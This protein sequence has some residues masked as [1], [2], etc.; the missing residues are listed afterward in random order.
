MKKQVIKLFRRMSRLI[1]ASM[2]FSAFRSPEGGNILVYIVMVMVIFAALGVTM[3]SLFSTS[4]GGSA[5]ADSERRAFNLY[6]SGY[7]Y[8]LSELTNTS[9]SSASINT[10]NTTTY[11]L[12][13]EGQF[14]LN[15]FGPWFDSVGSQVLSSGQLNLSLPRGKLPVD[16]TIPTG[17]PYVSVVNYDYPSASIP[18]SASAEIN[19][20]SLTD[21]THFTLNVRNDFVANAK[22]RICLAVH[23]QQDQAIAS[24]VPD[25]KVELQAQNIFPKYNGAI[26]VKRKLYFYRE[27]KDDSTNLVVTLTG[28]KDTSGSPPSFSVTTADY[29]ILS[30]ANYY[31]VPEGR[32]EAV[33]YG[34]KM[35]YAVNAYDVTPFGP[36]DPKPDIQFDQESDLS[37]KLT[38]NTTSGFAAVDNFNKKITFT[39][40]SGTPFASV[41]FN[42]TRAIGGQN[43]YCQSGACQF[44]AGIRAFFVM[45]FTGGGDGFTFSLLNASNNNTTSVGGD[46]Q[47][48]E[49]LGYAGDGRTGTNPATYIPLTLHGLQAPKMA[50]EFD[51]YYNNTSLVYCADAVNM[52]SGRFDP[53]FSGTVSGGKD[54][55]QYVFWGSRNALA[56]PCRGNSPLYDDNR[57]DS[58]EDSAGGEWTYPARALESSN[59]SLERVKIGPSPDG[60]VYAIFGNNGSSSDSRLVALD[61]S[62]GA[63]KWQIPTP[64]PTSGDDDIDAL[65]VDNAGNAYLGS[66]QHI[67]FAVKPDGSTALV[68]RH[69]Q[70]QCSSA[71]GRRRNAEPDLF[72][73]RGGTLCLGQE[74]RR[75]GRR[76]D[77]L[78]QS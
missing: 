64:I 44:N 51:G 62:S 4:T 59:T 3:L 16:F 19:G 53:A 78:F 73:V 71:H 1:A 46:F 29:V 56:A 2:S 13:P 10:L 38:Q 75:G 50:V 12:N 33:S 21:P 36:L 11:T 20:F 54:T 9:F 43:D 63:L 32:T 31:I 67:I 28:L 6:E 55:V 66:D 27:R 18:D 58:K 7:R 25:L 15:V 70:H 40:T 77:E 41:L 17:S 57:H 48:G 74:N 60:T 26:E 65:A 49:L 76:L 8:A 69:H 52:N 37:S 35:T 42:A 14:V 72:C 45:T 47:L 24:G 39:R 61:P 30:P 34:A 68:P 22:E 5:P 23:P